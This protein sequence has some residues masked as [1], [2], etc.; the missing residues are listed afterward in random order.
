MRCDLSGRPARAL[1]I[2][3]SLFW[4]MAGAQADVFDAH[5]QLMVDAIRDGDHGRVAAL[6][7]TPYIDIHEPV[8]AQALSFLYLAVWRLQPEI[9][10]TLLAAGASLKTVTKGGTTVWWQAINGGTYSSTLPADQAAGIRQRQYEVFARLYRSEGFPIVV[11]NKNGYLNPN[12][13]I[14]HVIASRCARGAENQVADGLFAMRISRLLT[15]PEVMPVSR[16]MLRE[17]TP[18]GLAPA[19][20][21]RAVGRRHEAARCD[22]LAAYYDEMA[23]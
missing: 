13:N 19:D 17:P 7:K 5:R 10:E 21:A 3:L 6:L 2:A 18:Q 15:E 9:V 22:E 4:F 8:G 20:V 16:L 1:A 12:G 14:F 11:R 23:K